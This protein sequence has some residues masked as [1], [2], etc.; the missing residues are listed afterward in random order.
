MYMMDQ[1]SDRRLLVDALRPSDQG[2]LPGIT[3]PVQVVTNLTAVIAETVDVKWSVQGQYR[4]TWPSSSRV[5]SCLPNS[6][7]AGW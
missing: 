5:G 3:V 1:A 7:P 4:I 6:D 2:W